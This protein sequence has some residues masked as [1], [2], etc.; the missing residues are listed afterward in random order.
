MIGRGYVNDFI[1]ILLHCN[2][3][4]WH[5]RGKLVKLGALKC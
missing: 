1:S 5:V 4:V 3:I 2:V